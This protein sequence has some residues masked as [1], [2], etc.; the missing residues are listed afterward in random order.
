MNCLKCN[1]N[2][3]SDNYI[4][5]NFYISHIHGWGTIDKEFN[6]E[7][8]LNIRSLHDRCFRFCEDCFNTFSQQLLNKENND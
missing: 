8:R 5:F 6:K 3:N 2:L 1:K 4:Y 7:T